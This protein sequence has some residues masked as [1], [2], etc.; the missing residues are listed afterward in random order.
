MVYYK[1]KIKN[2]FVVIFLLFIPNAFSSPT[3][4]CPNASKLEE[5]LISFSMPIDTRTNN[6]LLLQIES[7]Y[8][9]EVKK[10]I[11]KK[12]PVINGNPNGFFDLKTLDWLS[13]VVWN[14]EH[15]RTRFE[16]FFSR[17]SSI[18][19]MKD[20]SFFLIQALWKRGK[21]VTPVYQD[22]EQ[23]NKV[24]DY[25]MDNL[26]ALIKEANPHYTAATVATVK[27]YVES[28]YIDNK[29][30]LIGLSS[31]LQT[32]P[33]VSISA[34]G[35]AGRNTISLGYW[36]YS[37]E[38]VIKELKQSGISSGASIDL[39]TCFSG[40]SG[41]ELKYTKS[42]L[43]KA[44]IDGNLQDLVI[45][46]SNS[47]LGEF[48]KVIPLIIPDFKGR[49]F[50]YPGEPEFPFSDNVHN[51]DGSVSA[52]GFGVALSALDGEIIFDREESRLVIA[53]GEN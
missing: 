29:N 22:A 17:Y 36:D 52:R 50:G 3:G 49:L 13:A 20:F 18:S 4:A 5:S 35:K 40:C 15:A 41:E 1:M 23:A 33:E 43:K 45:D 7:L 24:N 2:F 53:F 46:L 12:H 28:Y 9:E 6:Q 32:N 48:S 38:D 8:G 31:I 37:A 51:R 10:G 27:H 26:E 16:F 30:Y 21:K 25:F 44:F 42:E 19:E 47:F 14:T 39:I 11:I 34:H